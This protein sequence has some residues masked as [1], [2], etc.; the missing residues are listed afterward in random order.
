MADKLT[1]YTIN[2]LHDRAALAGARFNFV[3]FSIGQP[4]RVVKLVASGYSEYWHLAG[5]DKYGNP[6]YSFAK[7]EGDDN[8]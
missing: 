1:G 3:E 2:M 7:S 5:E 6:L 4:A 8:E